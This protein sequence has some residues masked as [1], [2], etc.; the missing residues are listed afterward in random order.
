MELCGISGTHES[1][2]RH[3]SRTGGSQRP[4]REDSTVYAQRKTGYATGISEKPIQEEADSSYSRP[5]DYGGRR[6]KA[7][8]AIQLTCT[9]HPICKSKRPACAR[10]AQRAQDYN[11]WTG[12]QS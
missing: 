2:K 3:D 7:A 11:V 12:P 6:G 8:Q 9:V 10:P 5:C 4:V 1:R